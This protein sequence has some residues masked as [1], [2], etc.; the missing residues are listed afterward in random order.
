MMKFS[1]DEIFSAT[2]VV[3]NFSA[4]LKKIE[5]NKKVFVVKNNKF[6]CVMLNLNE[7]EKLQ[8]ALVILEAIYKD[9]KNGKN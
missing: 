4:I 6:Q 9:K 5:G 2:E 7:Y 3:R 8:N 1:Q